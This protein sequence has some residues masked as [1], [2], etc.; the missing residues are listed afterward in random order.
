MDGVH[1]NVVIFCA[2]A[3]RAHCGKGRPTG[4]RGARV[5]SAGRICRH[6]RLD[7]PRRSLRQKS[8]LPGGAGTCGERARWLERARN[9]DQQARHVRRR[10]RRGF[11]APGG[12]RRGLRWRR[13]DDFVGARR[14]GR[15]EPLKHLVV[16]DVVSR[17]AALRNVGVDAVDAN[18]VAAN[19]VGQTTWSRDGPGEQKKDAL[20]ASTRRNRGGGSWKA[21]WLRAVVNARAG[22]GWGFTPGGSAHNAPRIR[23]PDAV[24]TR[25]VRSAAKM[26]PHLRTRLQSGLGYGNTRPDRVRATTEGHDR[27]DRG[28]CAREYLVGRDGVRARGTAGPVEHVDGVLHRVVPK[29]GRRRGRRDVR[30]S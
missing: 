6:G 22:D 11:G 1:I 25:H 17:T 8:A 18:A 12:R 9:D 4:A 16:K 19:E 30:S 10:V 20:R 21:W 24:G 7:V 3:P 14:A 28:L 13:D 23:H 27:H 26:Y 5:G 29:R 15:E 2:G